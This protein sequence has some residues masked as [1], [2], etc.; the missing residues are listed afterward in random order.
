[1]H[2]T[3]SKCKKVYTVDASK[4]PPNV[5]KT[6]CKTCGAAISLRP[7]EQ[8][9]K[10][11]DASGA[12][13]KAPSDIIQITCQ[14]CSQQFKIKA[15][16]IPQGVTSTRCKSCGHKI[17]LKT[18]DT[19]AKPAEKVKTPGE[20]TAGILNIACLYCGK[21]YSINAAK[22]PPGV[23]TTK[24]KACGRP[25]SLVAPSP[26]AAPLKTDGEK[27][28][29]HTQPQK[30]Q[31]ASDSDLDAPV[32]A[33]ASQRVNPIWQKRRPLVA[34]AAILLLVLAGY[35]AIT[36]WSR[37][38]DSG[39]GLGNISA[40]KPAVRKQTSDDESKIAAGSR[41][42]AEPFFAARLNVPLLLAA[43]DQNTA[44]DKKNIRYKMTTTLIKSL[45]LTDVELYFYPHPQ[46]GVLP[47]IFASGEDGN[48]LKTLL[49][50]QINYVQVLEPHADGFYRIK[51]DAIPAD[52]Q[53]NFPIDL[54]R[55]QFIDNRA[56][57][58]PAGLINRFAEGPEPLHKTQ[59]AQMIA[60][61]AQPRDLAALSI[62]IPENLDT[63]WQKKIQSNPAVKQNPQ[64][65][66]MI[67]MG[68]GMVNQLSESLKD[69]DSLAIGFRLDEANGR[70]LSYTQQF[71]EGVDGKQIYRQL[72]AGNPD[73]LD[74][75]GT[76]LKLIELFND[77]RYKHTLAHKNNRLM[78]GL[79]W[80]QTQD[81]AILSALSEATIGQMLAQGMDLSPS[82][83]PVAAQYVDTPRIVPDVNIEALKKTIPA[84][85]ENNLFPGN[86]WSFG[87]E[88]RMTLDFDTL[89]IPNA[90]LA[91]LKYEV[92]E[93]LST[94]GADIRRV[95]EN[96]FQ[97]VINPGS[98]SPGFI[99]INVK[100]DTPAET[101]GTAK[102]QFKI[103][104]PVRLKIFEFA[105]TDDAP[106]T[107]RKSDGIS[108]K[109]RRLEKDVAK[110]SFRGGT[111][112]RLFAFDNTGRSLAS[113][114]SMSAASS[115]ASRFQGE[116]YRLQVVVV[117]EI[118]EHTF[119]VVANLNRGKELVLS[120]K[121]ET[122]ARLRYD[123][124][125]MQNFASYTE[126]ELN[127][128]DVKRKEAGGMMWTDSLQV[129]LPRGPF[130]G[131]IRWE[132]HFF[133]ERE[134]VYLSG[135]AFQSPA[136]FSYGLSNGELKNAHAAFG[137]VK[138]ELA[139]VIERI[140]FKKQADG[141]G[142]FQ[143]LP[144]GQPIKV[145]F[146]Q[147]EITLDAGNA[148]VIQSVAFDAQGLQLRK[149]G[150]TGINGNRKKMYFWGV[151]TRFVIDVATAKIN[152]TIDFDVRQRTVDETRYSKFKQDIANHR[153]I[154]KTLKQLASARRKDRTKYG[155]DIAGLFYLYGRK[156]KK[157]MAL[158]DKKVAHSDP[159]GQKRFGY[160][161]KPYKGYYFTVLSGV[162]SGGTQNDYMRLPKQRSYTWKKGS[163]KTTPFLQ[164]P[165]LVAIP[166]DGTQPTFF[167][168]FDQIF[169]KQLNGDKLTYLPEDY[170]S[171]GWVEAKFVEG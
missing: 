161:L 117:E 16:A 131:D 20:Q 128:L 11:P 58:A 29:P 167:M 99:E 24:C 1:M 152:K 149:D 5:S 52:K 136:G 137:K 102:I 163:F 142:S 76:V 104:L 33:D 8:R 151:P 40:K 82:E 77:P 51:K 130:S 34:V 46:H 146:N 145:V 60:A 43:V 170:Y 21:K 18:E 103:A 129:N 44:E 91:Q 81:E 27:P 84:A 144:S 118:F 39:L 41:V 171:T 56:I 134:P 101:L 10:A 133:G 150:Y 120:H 159:A 78:I 86:Y 45:G 22:I 25:M 148:D 74:V 48:S 89:A 66:M 15:Q 6:P 73:D 140:T 50:S 69:V 35:F 90:S 37:L 164:P 124:R 2:I 38:S 121:P 59:V 114:E 54:Y 119:D 109:L 53:N 42:A 155:D 97:H 28:V 70:V 19:A 94:D 160:T 17:S 13:P 156:Q 55:V 30:N 122:P 31:K 111:S 63:D 157:P 61:I 106:G 68:G 23:K 93:V 96:T 57:F 153:D 108:V 47:V 127:D 92:S 14:Y 139:S 71:R 67:A 80:E 49:T 162:E 100:K 75:D 62:R 112:A 7:T 95:E 26:G 115:A 135:N 116:I 65:A 87:D 138:M 165:D 36:Q 143:K 72:K 154:V 110:I 9:K 32:I 4:I 126:N 98:A 85:V 64:A 3:C 105:S 141:K 125:P 123:H 166:K 158:I 12:L 132:V 169:M 88:P 168:Q 79:N 83:G 107:I 113:R 147:N